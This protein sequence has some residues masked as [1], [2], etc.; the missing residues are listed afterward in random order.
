MAP[1]FETNSQAWVFLGMV[2]LGL[3]LGLIYDGLSPL[4]RSR[5]KGLTACM[6]LIFFLLAGAALTLALVVTGQDGL[7]LYALLGLLCGGILY[8]MGLRRL[9]LGVAAFFGKR[10]VK[11]AK[12]AMARARERKALRKSA[13]DGRKRPK[14]G[15]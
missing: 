15:E 11:P 5:K 1:F 6:D 10:I 7:R 14:G 4:R 9:L 13:R 8:L 2:Y 3:A 12:E